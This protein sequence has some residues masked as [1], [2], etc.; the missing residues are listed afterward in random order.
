MLLRVDGVEASAPRLDA[1]RKLL[2]DLRLK[3]K[4]VVAYS[5]GADTSTYLLLSAASQVILAPG[6][7]LHLVGFSLTTTSLKDALEKLGV[8]PEFFRK[9]KYKTAPEKFTR[10]DTSPEQRQ[11]LDEIL[12][13]HHRRLVEGLAARLGG[14]EPARA[15]VDAGPYTAR[16]ALEARLV[17]R[18]AYRDELPRVLAAP[19]ETKARIG[20]PRELRR[21][22]R[23][24]FEPPRLRPR[25]EVAV[26]PISGLIKPGKSF[27]WPG[28][29]GMAGSDSVVEALDRARK[30]KSARGVLVHVDSRGGAAP[31]SELMWRAVLRCAEEKPT[32]A[33]VD[34]VAASGGYFAAAG[35][36]RIVAAPSS[37]VGSIG[38]FAGRFD[39]RALLE[40]LGVK[41][42]VFLRGAH[43]GLLEPAHEL[44]DEER[45]V[46][47]RDIEDTYDEFVSR[48]AEG[49]RRRPE[50]IRAA[51]EGRVWVAAD[52]PDV[53][54]DERGGL[55]AALAWLGREG[56][57]DPADAELRVVERI[58]ARPDLG[59]LFGLARSF[60]TLQPLLLWPEL[61]A[62]R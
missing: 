20:S 6:S 38:V 61:Y 27:R 19:G 30:S 22:V 48:V 7:P 13:H 56:R 8:N 46:L 50:E 21:S 16:R 54:V 17:D 49:R 44:T 59:D 15:A 14:E 11:V 60:A 51:A 4:E 12:D 43:A 25:P 39:A 62:V 58:G 26:V 47:V 33:F 9:G 24:R 45:Q 31:A 41:Q 53:L 57:F 29:A 10:S 18:L 55:D 34:G 36:R 37:L 1:L 52:A 32:I 28:G 42:E 35:A 2:V 3:G 40:R 23:F 5:E